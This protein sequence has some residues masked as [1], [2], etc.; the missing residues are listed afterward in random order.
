MQYTQMLCLEPT[1]LT[2]KKR[3]EAAKEISLFSASYGGSHENFKVD[4]STKNKDGHEIDVD[5]YAL[6]CVVQNILQRGKPAKPS[7]FLQ[8]N[9][10]PLEGEPLY[11]V[12]NNPIQWNNIKGDA[13]NNINPARYFFDSYLPKCLPD[14]YAFVRNLF[15]P[16]ADFRYILN[17]DINKSFYGQQ[18]DFYLPQA[19]LVIEIDGSGHESTSQK[20]KDSA[21]DAELSA[22]GIRVVRIK[23]SDWKQFNDR[24]KQFISLMIK[25]IREN[26]L[27]NRYKQVLES[28]N[29]NDIRLKYE[30]VMR[31][32]I[33]LINYFMRGGHYQEKYFFV[34]V[35]EHDSEIKNAEAL[36]KIAYDDL[37]DWITAIARLAKVDFALPEL[38]IVKNTNDIEGTVTVDCSLFKRYTDVD[39][40]L[41]TGNYIYIR[42]AYIPDNDYYQIAAAPS[43]QYHFSP[44]STIKDNDALVF[45][46]ENL[47]NYKE[48]RNGQLE[49]IKNALSREDTIG[50]LPTG[51]GKSLCYQMAALLQPGQTLVTVPILSLIKDQIRSMSENRITRVGFISSEVTKQS[52]KIL[53]DFESGKYQFMLFAPE[54]IQ[55]NDFLKSLQRINQ[56]MTFSYAVIDEVHCL[57]EWGHDFRVSYLMLVPSLRRYCNN[58]C[59]IGL[60]ATAS[61]AVLDDIKAEFDNDGSAVKALASMDRNELEFIKYEVQNDDERKEK[62]I[63]IILKNDKKRKYKDANGNVKN[64]VGLVFCPTVDVNLYY[65]NKPSCSSIYDTLTKI[66]ELN[67]RVNIFHGQLTPEE[68]NNSQVSFMAKEYSGVMVC[69]KAFGMGIDKEN[70]RYTVHAAQPQSIESFYQ[71]AGRA[72]RDADKSLRSKCYI[73]YLPESNKESVNSVFNKDTSIEK[74]KAISKGLKGDLSTTMFLWN[75]E[76]LSVDEEYRKIN[77]ILVSLY[78]RSE[79]TLEFD[80]RKKI[81]QEGWRKKKI[82][83]PLSLSFRQNALYKLGLLKI[84]TGWTIKYN[85][86]DSGTIHVEPGYLDEEKNKEALL[87]YIKKHDPE[88]T[89]DE[90]TESCKHYQEILSTYK[91]MK[92]PIEGLIR[93][94]IEWSN[95][96]I[97]YSRLQSL[98]TMVQLCSNSVSPTEFRNRIND[99]FKYTEV[100]VTFDEIAHNPF[101]IINWF[102]VLF[103]NSGTPSS[104]NLV[105]KK[106]ARRLLSTL[107]RYLESYGNSTGLN[108]LS[109]IL[110]LICSD[111]KGTEGEYRIRDAFKNIKTKNDYKITSTVF[112]N[113]LLIA[114][115]LDSDDQNILTQILLEYYPEKALEIHEKLN[116]ICSTTFFIKLKTKL[117]AE[118][119]EEKLHGLQ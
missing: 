31:L 66:P 87:S 1:R 106:E 51:T 21:R 11:L 33:G 47:F 91:N 20:Y 93:I 43:I 111:F 99:Y 5:L 36:F 58:I 114:M 32:Q 89:L 18:V 30:Y 59:L 110:R 97:Q 71:E 45:L 82:K 86:I 42:T 12:S 76:K 70:I 117:I 96:K 102:R 95:D 64:I 55:N 68:R 100:A 49:I 6:L 108:Y 104:A 90:P 105:Q 39:N 23:T 22:N 113:T 98:Y 63:E 46:L 81:V 60:T 78:T 2:E 7:H 25:I 115:T 57:S 85:N 38:K 92:K 56:S 88:F 35:I 52:G 29:P 94:L 13:E 17:N 10:G 37:N 118:I 62:I 83:N 15:L 50:L 107:S 101:V 14:G 72:G 53:K 3:Y 77:E 61:Q 26:P 74:R 48:F 65:K 109:G 19:K 73:V 44:D 112:A 28:I 79:N 75:E 67:N 34:N 119:W 116:N 41:K 16:E 54:R 24:F 103:K 80:N 69:T 8:T 84:V 40:Y 4:I 9:L 27:I